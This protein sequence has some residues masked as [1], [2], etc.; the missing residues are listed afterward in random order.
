MTFIYWLGNNCDLW[1]VI[2]WRGSPPYKQIMKTAVTWFGVIIPISSEIRKMDFKSQIRCFLTARHYKPP[3][4]PFSSRLLHNHTTLY[5]AVAPRCTNLT[6]HGHTRSQPY[7]AH[8]VHFT[9]LRYLRHL[10][11]LEATRS[12]QFHEL[13][14][15]CVHGSLHSVNSANHERRFK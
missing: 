12:R 2:C 10:A 11:F 13:E 7:V 9:N 6:A 1:L 15:Q 14:L 3:P 8:L 5:K 4:L